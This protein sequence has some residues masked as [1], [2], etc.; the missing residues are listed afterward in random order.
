MTYFHIRLSTDLFVK[1]PTASH[2]EFNPAILQ[3]AENHLY[4][5]I[6]AL[7]NADKEDNRTHIHI[8]GEC[9]TGLNSQSMRRR[10]IE[11]HMP[12]GRGN[13]SIRCYDNAP[14]KENSQEKKIPDARGY[15]YV[16][17]GKDS[18]EKTIPCIM[19]KKGFTDE[20]INELHEQYWA[21]NKIYQEQIRQSQQPEPI[22][23][24]LSQNPE[25]QRKKKTI[26]WT[27]ALIEEINAV[28][29]DRTW[30]VYLDVDKKEIC[31]LILDRMGRGGKALDEMI[32]KRIFYAVYNGIRKTNQNKTAFRQKFYD[33][34]GIM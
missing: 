15:V 11:A 18:Y 14:Y 13:Y 22:K 8:H 5:Y 20:D 21:E 28:Y 10:W 12:Q 23:C 32:F 1:V 9:G 16:C 24:D 31:D 7:E 34:V 17:K 3:F 27:Q 19:G 33:C 6:I 30:N 29:P 2:S 26:T 4:K 25:V